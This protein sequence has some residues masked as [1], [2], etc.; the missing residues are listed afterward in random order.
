PCNSP[1]R[2]ARRAGT[3]PYR[4]RW[5]K[6]ETRVPAILAVHSAC[7]TQTDASPPPPKEFALAEPNTSVWDIHWPFCPSARPYPRWSNAAPSVVVRPEFQASL[8]HSAK[9]PEHN[10]GLLRPAD[11][12]LLEIPAAMACLDCGSNGNESLSAAQRGARSLS[13]LRR[14][15]RA[16]A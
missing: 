14:L 16:E 3:S 1:A 13:Q 7:P 10:R 6:L 5:P 11:F 2:L 4:D 8:G 9:M 15:V 12:F